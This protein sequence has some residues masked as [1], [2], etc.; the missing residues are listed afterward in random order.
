MGWGLLGLGIMFLSVDLLKWNGMLMQ[1]LVGV[2]VVILN[3]AASKLFIFK[4]D[5]T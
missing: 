3:Y 1:V 5:K 4:G 2:L